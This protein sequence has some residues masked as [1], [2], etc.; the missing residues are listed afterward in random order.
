MTFELN[1]SKEI[2][3]LIR[4]VAQ[5]YRFLWVLPVEGNK[6]EFH[7]QPSDFSKVL[8]R[9]NAIS[10]WTQLIQITEYHTKFFENKAGYI[11]LH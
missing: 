4:L 7:S 8:C 2:I 1:D 9:C 5:K 11:Y 10:E 6:G 3:F